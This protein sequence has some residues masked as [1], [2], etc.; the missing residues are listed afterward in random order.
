MIVSRLSDYLR[1]RRRASLADMANGLDA[2]PTALEA[3]LG[4]LERKGRVRR[5]PDGS[6]CGKS[7]CSCDST[8]LALYEWVGD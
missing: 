8:T 2:T 5:L 7:C 6:A 4:V 1:E 3:M